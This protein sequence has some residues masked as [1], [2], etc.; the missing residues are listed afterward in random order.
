MHYYLL[1]QNVFEPSTMV[2]EGY[3]FIG[4]NFLRKHNIVKKKMFY[5]LYTYMYTRSTLQ[6]CNDMLEKVALQALQETLTTRVTG[7]K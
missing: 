7:S 3:L 5:R 1:L 2:V 4:K 6:L